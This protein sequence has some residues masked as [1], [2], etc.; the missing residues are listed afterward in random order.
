MS[1]NEIHYRRSR[2]A[3]RLL[4]NRLYTAGH[5]WLEQKSGTVW[6]IGF[7][8]FATRMLGEIVEIGFEI[9]PGTDVETGQIVGWVEGFKA[10]TDI[11]SPL[12]GYF[13]VSNPSLY[14]DVALVT[15]EPYSKGWL[16]EVQGEPGKDCLDIHGYISILDTTIDKMLGKRDE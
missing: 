11:F 1:S 14:K 8:K 3:T 7:T 5:C 12:S 15:N 2:F 4:E 6:R 10:V 9:K 16:F 13:K